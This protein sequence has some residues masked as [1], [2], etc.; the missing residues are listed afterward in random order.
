MWIMGQGR[1]LSALLIPGVPDAQ[2]TNRRIY[3]TT[4]E[5]PK[6]D[7]L[8]DVEDDDIQSLLM[9]GRLGIAQLLRERG[10]APQA[11]G[12]SMPPVPPPAAPPLPPASAVPLAPDLIAELLE[13]MA[14][15]S[16]AE[17]PRAERLIGAYLSGR[18]NLPE[19]LARCVAA[20]RAAPDASNLA[21]SPPA[22]P[23]TSGERKR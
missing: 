5:S 8:A 2:A 15:L 11:P 9:A 1:Q 17:R 3:Y 19:P 13:R 12:K 10:L 20:Y 6:L 16:E 14:S 4:T 7:S 23:E 18:P 22:V 21:S